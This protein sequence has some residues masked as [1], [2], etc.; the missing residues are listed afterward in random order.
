MPRNRWNCESEYRGPGVRQ[1]S[2]QSCL[3]YSRWTSMAKP[4]TRFS[5]GMASSP[6]P[7]RSHRTLS[8]EKPWKMSRSPASM[9]CWQPRRTLF[10]VGSFHAARYSVRKVSFTRSSNASIE[11][12]AASP[13]PASC[14]RKSSRASN[15]LRWRCTWPPRCT[16]RSSLPQ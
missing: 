3:W 10:V 14:C 1:F 4:A 5:S 8:S 15:A 6:Q 9:R 13:V 16:I 2:S 7:A 11:Y 12:S